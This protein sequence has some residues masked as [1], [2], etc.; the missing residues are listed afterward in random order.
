[1]LITKEHEAMVQLFGTHEEYVSHHLTSTPQFTKEQVSQSYDIK[2]E[3][4][5][6]MSNNIR[7]GAWEHPEQDQIL[8]YHSCD[9]PVCAEIYMFR[10]CPMCQEEVF[11]EEIAEKVETNNI[12][13][14]ITTVPIWIYD[15]Y[16]HSRVTICKVC[17]EEV[18]G[19]LAKIYGVS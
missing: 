4:T 16:V 5:C 2:T 7:A 14:P 3:A 11:N 13:V 9:D 17:M 18:N 10:K 19:K 8:N 1:M 6:V 15:H 12:D